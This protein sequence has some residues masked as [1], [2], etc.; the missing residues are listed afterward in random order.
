MSKLTE[1]GF[2]HNITAKA[3]ESLRL[4]DM[5]KLEVEVISSTST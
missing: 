4:F 2:T 1:N 5:L 3:D